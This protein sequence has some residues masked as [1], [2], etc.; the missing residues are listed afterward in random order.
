MVET[1]K[2]EKGMKEVYVCVCVFMG[3][4]LS[5]ILDVGKGFSVPK[6]TFV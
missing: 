6:P 3:A 5:C 2:S 4:G 1:R